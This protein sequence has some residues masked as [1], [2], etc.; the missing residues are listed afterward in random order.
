[1]INSNGND[2]DDDDDEDNKEEKQKMRDDKLRTGN[3]N[4]K[5]WMTASDNDMPTQSMSLTAPAEFTT[6]SDLA[7]SYKFSNLCQFI[8]ASYNLKSYRITR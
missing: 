8:I 1:M 2:H 6:L 7:G 5:I 4:R 3:T